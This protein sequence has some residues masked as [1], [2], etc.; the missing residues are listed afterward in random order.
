MEP[1]IKSRVNR[2]AGEMGKMAR[3]EAQRIA[4][5]YSQAEQRSQRHISP[6]PSGTGLGEAQST[7]AATCDLI[8]GS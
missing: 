4:R 2:V 6:Q 3:R 5:S 8:R 1:L 7:V